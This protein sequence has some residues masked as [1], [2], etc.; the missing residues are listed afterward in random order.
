ML[1][2]DSSSFE[3]RRQSQ[4]LPQKAEKV[5]PLIIERCARGIAFF[6][7]FCTLSVLVL[8]GTVVATPMPLRE[9]CDS[10]IRP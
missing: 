5:V 7:S 6:F 2:V 3:K 1:G 9:N 8:P 4:I 10:K